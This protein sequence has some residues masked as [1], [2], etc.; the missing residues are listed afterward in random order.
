MMS[1]EGREAAIGIWQELAE[2]GGPL[3]IP[4]RQ[5]QAMA[6][7]RAGKEAEALK[8]VDRLLTEAQLPKNLRRSMMCEKA[9]MLMLL[10]K[11][12]AAAL[13]SAI[14]VLQ[15]MVRE[16]D[17]PFDWR[18]RAGYT[19]AVALQ[20]AGQATEALEA[21]Y[22]VVEADG[23]TGPSDPAEFRWY[24]RAGFFGID[25]LEAA[26]QWEAAARL[27]EKLA[28]SSGER[29]A[30]AKERATKIRLEHFLWDGK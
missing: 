29:A 19:L 9:E 8:L 20:S 30:E 10:G 21:C 1:D 22:D 27:A 6:L 17:L 26:K 24:Y 23:F 18:A 7:R 2:R 14:G 13:T 16:N 15:E 25:L 28:V 12:D 4:A 5:Q 3:S 11:T